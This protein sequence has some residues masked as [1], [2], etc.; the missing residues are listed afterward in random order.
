VA[1][2]EWIYRYRGVITALM[3][4]GLLCLPVGDFC[5]YFWILIFMAAFLRIWARM[6]IGEHSR[7]DRLDCPALVQTGPYRYVKHPL[8]LANFM[9]GVGFA[10]LHVGVTL[11]G[12]PY[13]LG[14]CLVY[15][16]FLLILINN[17]NK[18]LKNKEKTPSFTK[19]SVKQAIINDFATWIWQAIMI[20]LILLRKILP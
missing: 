9:A 12:Y 3:G 2:G 10:G 20:I 11:R 14:F 6:H 16:I 5:H 13:A 18:F 15:G 1:S 17:E 8:Y 4:L 19:Q 7:G